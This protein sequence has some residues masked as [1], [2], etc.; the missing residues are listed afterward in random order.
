MVV[1]LNPAPKTA[2]I[3]IGPLRRI[4]MSPLQRLVIN[5]LQRLVMRNEDV[6]KAV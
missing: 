5:L 1:Y 3:V 2:L 6:V 4:V